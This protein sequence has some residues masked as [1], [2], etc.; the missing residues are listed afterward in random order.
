M[1]AEGGGG[2]TV[3]SCVSALLELSGSFSSAETVAVLEIVPP[4]CAGFTVTSIVTVHV[5]PFARD[6][7]VQLTTFPVL[8]EQS[9]PPSWI[10]STEREPGT[11]SNRTTFDAA[12]GPS[13][14]TTRS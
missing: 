14:V 4:G 12:S 9:P 5:P 7:R 1:S 13:F 6:A 8:A 2:G 3:V 10:A 11:E